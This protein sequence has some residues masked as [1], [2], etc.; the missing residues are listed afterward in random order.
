VH[1]RHQSRCS[2]LP[3]HYIFPLFSKCSLTTHLHV[4]SAMHES[5]RLRRLG[6]V[7]DSEY[8]ALICVVCGCALSCSGCQVTSHL[9]EKHQVPKDA[10]TSITSYI[11]SL[12]LLDLSRLPP[13][14]NGSPAHTNLKTKR[15]Y[16]CKLCDYLTASEE[17]IGRHLS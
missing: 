3:H 9:W 17:R 16:A 6:L 11:H 12:R 14:P 5:N 2:A 8:R 13:R 1:T 15:G 10:R 4:L 7:V